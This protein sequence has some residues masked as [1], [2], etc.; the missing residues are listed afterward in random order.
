MSQI[1][2]ES[3][4]AADFEPSTTYRDV[5][6]LLAKNPEF[7]CR[8]GQKRGKKREGRFLNHASKDESMADLTC[9]HFIQTKTN[10]EK[11]TAVRKVDT[12]VVSIF[13]GGSN[14]T[15]Q[16]VFEG[17]AVLVS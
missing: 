8:V 6:I 7:F 1:A 11:T 3:R 12:L 16:R 5:A 14:V 13:K 4:R 17:E 2:L 15:R 9:L 10:S